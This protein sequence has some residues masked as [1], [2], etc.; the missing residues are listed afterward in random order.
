MTSVV[1]LPSFDCL[2]CICFA[3]E[4]HGYESGEKR[5]NSDRRDCP[6]QPESIPN[7]PSKQRADGVTQISPETIDAEGTCPPGWMRGV[8]DGCEQR[9][10]DHRGADSEQRGSYQPP[11]EVLRCSGN[12]KACRLHPHAPDDQAFAS[13]AVAEWSGDGLQYTPDRGI[14]RLEHADALYAEA[15]GGEEKIGKMAQLIPSFKLFTR[16]A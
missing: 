7:H 1:K 15:V 16:P 8:R 6:I 5:D 4:N 3:H 2:R 10:V 12:D 14:D 9:R 11:A 13:P